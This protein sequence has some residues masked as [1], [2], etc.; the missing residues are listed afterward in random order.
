MAQEIQINT[1]LIKY[2]LFYGIEDVESQ[3]SEEE[4]C[5]MTDL[6]THSFE[7][8]VDAKNKFGNWDEHKSPFDFRKPVLDLFIE[9]KTGLKIQS[10]WP[11]GNKFAVVLSHDVDRFETYS[12][13][14]FIRTLKKRIQFSQTTKSHVKLLLNLAKTSVK[15]IFT[16]KSND[17]LWCYE[18]WIDL[19]KKFNAKSTF[20]M[21]SCFF[22]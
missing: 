2:L 13:K 1:S 6:L 7:T 14:G 5:W 17:P 12:P 4:L 18:K 11:N 21:F 16:R 8:S 3:F 22:F 15:M 10:I 19:E 9:T 20:F